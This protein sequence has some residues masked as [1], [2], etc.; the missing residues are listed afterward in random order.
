MNISPIQSRILLSINIDH[1]SSGKMFLA[2]GPPA[3]NNLS[4]FLDNFTLH[5][6]YVQCPCGVE[7]CRP[8]NECGNKRNVGSTV[9][10]PDL[11]DKTWW[12]VA[13]LRALPLWASSQE[14]E[15]RQEQE[16]PPFFYSSLTDICLWGKQHRGNKSHQS[17]I[18]TV[19][20]TSYCCLS[21]RKQVSFWAQYV[22]NKK[23]RTNRP[24][25][26][27][28]RRR[29]NILFASFLSLAPTL[30]SSSLGQL[31]LPLAHMGR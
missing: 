4:P 1:I 16:N 13:G 20:L 26:K 27:T 3:K 23:L 18:M 14:T 17:Q 8:G 25:A 2:Q 12:A 11:G 19:S 7:H 9:A 28:W 22:S 10:T 21:P 5:F 6:W 15:H 29:Q 30:T 31:I 24:V